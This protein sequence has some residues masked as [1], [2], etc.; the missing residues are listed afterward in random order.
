MPTKL[1]SPTTT[2]NGPGRQKPPHPLGR[3]LPRNRPPTHPGRMLLEEFLKPMGI[4]QSALA[5]RL[6]ISFPRINEVIRG[7]RGVT[8]D[9]ALRLSRVVGMSADF[10]LGL[11]QDW[12]LWHALRSTN[13]AAIARLE[14]LH[15]S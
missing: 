5:V 11:Q 10:W 8:T 3:R 1:K 7:K 6:G 9:T 13:A 12:D 4:S 2:N 15:R 14:P